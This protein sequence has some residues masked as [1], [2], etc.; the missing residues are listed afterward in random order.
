MFLKAFVNFSNLGEIVRN[1]SNSPITHS[2]V[3]TLTRVM[4]TGSVE[5]PNSV[6]G[7]AETLPPANPSCLHTTAASLS[8][9]PSPQ[10]VPHWF[11]TRPTCTCPMYDNWLPNNRI[12]SNL[13]VNK[14]TRFTKLDWPVS[15]VI[16][17]S[18]SVRE[19]WIQLGQHSCAVQALTCRD[20]PRQHRF[21]CHHQQFCTTLLTLLMMTVKFMLATSIPAA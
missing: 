18:L 13:S 5:L 15:S 16:K 19:I 17:T 10:T 1:Y 14:Q 8:P 7:R 21:N 3:A 2:S 4:T 9:H 20:G 12:R 11:S 6:F